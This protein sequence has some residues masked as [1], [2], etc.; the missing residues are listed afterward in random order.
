MTDHFA[1]QPD[2]TY[3][4]IMVACE[5]LLRAGYTAEAVSVLAKCGGCYDELR[6]M[7]LTKTETR[8]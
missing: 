1:P 7:L 3:Y 4:E 8:Q 2:P 6:E 5:T